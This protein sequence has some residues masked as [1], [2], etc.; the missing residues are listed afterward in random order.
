[1]ATKEDILEQIVEEYL[2]HKGY[3]VQHNL[4]FLPRK[5][6]PDFITN[7]DSNHSDIDVIGYHP[8]IEGGRKVMVVSC[9]SWQ[10]GFNPASE[11]DAI[12]NDK[13]RRGR[14]AWQA[15][16]E[17]TV[18]K[19]S[20]AF[21]KAV[22][23]ATGSGSFT[24]VT[25]VTRLSGDKGVWEAHEPFRQAIGGNPVTILTFREMVTEI[26]LQLTTTLAATEVGRMLQLFAAAEMKVTD[27]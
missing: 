12:I 3:F 1:M 18:P 9:K 23:D 25:A 24:Y 4:K 11:L 5:D 6:H 7:Q 22:R 26:Q 14:K 2:V 17:L 13:V 20:E 21:L 19:W 16:R 15:F 27:E 10:Q 8:L